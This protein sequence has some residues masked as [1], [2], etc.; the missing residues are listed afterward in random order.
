MV[1]AIAN[2]IKRETDK[3]FLFEA[4]WEVWLPK[5]QIEVYR[6]DGL[7]VVRMPQWLHSKNRQAFCIT[8][9]KENLRDNAQEVVQIH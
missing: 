5:S 7:I 2:S 1:Y 6:A 8:T 3:A 4:N 9:S